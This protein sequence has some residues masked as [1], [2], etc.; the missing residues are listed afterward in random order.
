MHDA[1]KGSAQETKGEAQMSNRAAVIL[2]GLIME[3]ALGALIVG[4]AL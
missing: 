4:M 1:G 3:L 2:F